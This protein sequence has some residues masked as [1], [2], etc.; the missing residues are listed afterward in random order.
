MEAEY[1]LIMAGEVPED[2]AADGDSVIA[3]LRENGRVEDVG[4]AE[5]M[6]GVTLVKYPRDMRMIRDDLRK[7]A[8]EAS[9]QA[10]IAN[11]CGI[12]NRTDWDALAAALDHAAQTA[13]ITCSRLSDGGD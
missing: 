7:L 3:W 8:D 12:H 4:T 9:D 2:H 13:K 5:S 11:K 10:S 1:I 6:Q